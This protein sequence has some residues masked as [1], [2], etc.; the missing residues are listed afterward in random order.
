MYNVYY[1]YYLYHLYHLYYLI[2]G[3]SEKKSL[4]HSLTHNLKSRDASASK[5]GSSVE[6]SSAKLQH[7]SIVEVDTEA[8]VDSNI[9]YCSKIPT[10]KNGLGLK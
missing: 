10:C 1:V 8:E 4:A 2:Y 7:R 9:N 6:H 3:K 5:K